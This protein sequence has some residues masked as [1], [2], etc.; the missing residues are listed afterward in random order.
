MSGYLFPLGSKATTSRIDQG[1]DFG[2]TGPIKAI[3]KAKIIRTGA[4]G[5]PG[6]AGILYQL[7]DGPAKGKYVYVNEGVKPNVRAGQMVAAG[8]TIG[9]LIPGTSTGIEMGWANSQGVPISHGEYTEGKETKGGKNFRGFLQAIKGEKPEP[10]VLEQAAEWFGVISS[11]GSAPAK[12]APK[13]ANA[14]G[15]V[16]GEVLSGIAGD[17]AKSA[18]SLMLNIA[19]IGGGAFLVYYGSALALGAKSPVGTPVKKA[20]ETAAAVAAAPK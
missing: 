1:V 11:P 9:S 7:L 15:G 20:A 4:P 13:A 3:G 14:V 2:G 6:G 17:F 5:W 8:Q 19:L 18:E 12:A 16:A 10:S